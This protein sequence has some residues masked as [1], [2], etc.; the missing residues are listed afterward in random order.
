MPRRA[1]LVID[2]QQG[3][4]DDACRLLGL[5]GVIARIN[6]LSTRARE[7]GAPVIFVQHEG[8]DGYLEHGTPGW[9]LHRDLHVGAQDLKMRKTATDAFHRT[10]LQAV[11]ERHGVDELVV[12]GMHTE[13]CV[14]TTIRRALALGYPVVLAAD[15][16]TSEGSAALAPAQVI[17]HHN[18]VLSNITSFGPQVRPV[19][20][21]DVTFAD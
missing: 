1:L 11:L 6:A 20:A 2:V 5:D 15:A 18:D 3:L 7:A 10:E 9:R 14:D 12:C 21:A 13:F 4:C 16:H 19:P 17:A 8:R